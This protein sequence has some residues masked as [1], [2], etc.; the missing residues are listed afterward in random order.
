V[1]ASSVVVVELLAEDW[2]MIRSALQTAGL[3]SDNG[4]S[5]LLEL[6]LDRYA[7]DEEEWKALDGRPEDASQVR[8]Q[9]LKRREAQAHLVS[10]RASTIAAEKVMHEL[11]ARVHVLAAEL[12]GHRSTMWPLRE[13]NASLDARLQAMHGPVDGAPPP[14]KRR[15]W[16]TR[17]TRLFRRRSDGHE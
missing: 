11:G 8:R 12:Y 9:E 6:G 10:M 1:S 13:E 7:L 4:L 17:L 16:L 3:D 15:T 14:D 2:A 5:W